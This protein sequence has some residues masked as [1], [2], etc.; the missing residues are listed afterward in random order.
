MTECLQR[1]GCR[2]DPAPDH[3][4]GRQPVAIFLHVLERPG[5]QEPVLP[6]PGMRQALHRLPAL[7]EDPVAGLDQCRARVLEPG[8]V[9]GVE[10]VLGQSPE[11]PAVVLIVRGRKRKAP[12]AVEH[13]LVI[14]EAAGERLG[15]LVPHPDFQPAPG[16]V[17][18]APLVQLLVDHAR[19]VAAVAV[20]RGADRRVH[21]L[22][23]ARHGR[24]ADLHVGQMRAVQ[25]IELGHGSPDLGPALVL[26]PPEGR[27][28]P[29]RSHR[30]PATEADRAPP[31]CRG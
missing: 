20:G 26:A 19:L 22:G 23:C 30:N 6:P 15:P 4:V 10:R 27:K 2:I 7:A 1:G 14:A 12:R 9:A 24:I 8:A 25:C 16:V 21:E 17:G 31:G 3:G 29:P 13:A 28:L 5:G 18:K 11:N